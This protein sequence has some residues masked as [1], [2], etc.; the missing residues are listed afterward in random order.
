MSGAGVDRKVGLRKSLY[1]AYQT[2]YWLRIEGGGGG[3]LPAFCSKGGYKVEPPNC[4]PAA[5]DTKENT[6]P[7]GTA[8]PRRTRRTRGH[9]QYK[10][11]KI[12]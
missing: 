7:E 11:L 3:A 12:S 4:S 8:A 1:E 2:F 10:G 5:R 6:Y 9:V